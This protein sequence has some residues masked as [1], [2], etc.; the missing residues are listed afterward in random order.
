MAHNLLTWKINY[1]SLEVTSISRESAIFD[2]GFTS[3]LDKYDYTKREEYVS[4]LFKILEENN[5]KTLLDIYNL[6]VNV[7]SLLKSMRG[8][9][10]L[11]RKMNKDFI[12]VIFETFK[13][14]FK[15]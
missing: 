15:L 14:N 9:N 1:T 2:E 8:L 10:P 3:W 4:S 6:R 11:V 13:E 7:I 12:K 5:V